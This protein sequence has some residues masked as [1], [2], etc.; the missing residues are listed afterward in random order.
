MKR[1]KFSGINQK[2]LYVKNHRGVFIIAV[3]YING[4]SYPGKKE[5]EFVESIHHDSAKELK[6]TLVPSNDSEA[7]YTQDK[8]G[9]KYRYILGEI[10]FA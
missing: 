6:T 9:F 3:I 8:T 10:I 7:Y 1:F 5:A 4:W 2:I